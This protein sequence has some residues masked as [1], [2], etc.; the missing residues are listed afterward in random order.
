MTP[1]L[2][3]LTVKHFRGGG[4]NC[5]LFQSTCSVTVQRG[6]HHDTNNGATLATA[7]I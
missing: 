3:F 5:G 4:K 2:F 6:L 7:R 1:F